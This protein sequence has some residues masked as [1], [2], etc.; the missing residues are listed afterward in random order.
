MPV[1]KNMSNELRELDQLMSR[2][3]T[4][5]IDKLIELVHKF[6]N[7]SEEDKDML[8]KLLDYKKYETN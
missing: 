2:I 6:K 1:F 8:A 4:Y 3:N 5:S 7:M